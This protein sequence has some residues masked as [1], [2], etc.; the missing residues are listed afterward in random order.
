MRSRSLINPNQIALL[1]S[2]SI[3]LKIWWM[4][5]SERYDVILM[6]QVSVDPRAEFCLPRNQMLPDRT[7][8]GCRNQKRMRS[9]RWEPHPHGEWK[10][11]WIFPY[12][13]NTPDSPRM[14]KI[15]ASSR[16]GFQ[17][18]KIQLPVW[19]L[20]D[21]TFYK[22]VVQIYAIINPSNHSIPYTQKDLIP[23][24]VLN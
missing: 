9:F 17:L 24:L 14:G 21:W 15:C 20:G 4:V 23:L 8:Q 3:R 16:I 18:K 5:S 1:M 12:L 11:S 10:C 22:I 2:C 19:R 6:L 7:R 13:K